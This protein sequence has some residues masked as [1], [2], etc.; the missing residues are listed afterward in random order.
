MGVSIL[1]G[2]EFV[3][4]RQVFVFSGQVF[5]IDTTASHSALVQ[6]STEV[7][8]TQTQTLATFA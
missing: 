3:L 5:V 1:L 4:P 7:A 8:E 6:I 2:K